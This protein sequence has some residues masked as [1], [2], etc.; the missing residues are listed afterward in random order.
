VASRKPPNTEQVRC[1]MNAQTTAGVVIGAGMFVYAGRARGHHRRLVYLLH[2]RPAYVDQKWTIP[3]RRSPV[4][5]LPKNK[6][7]RTEISPAVSLAAAYPA[8][9]ATSLRL[10][11]ACDRR[12]PRCVEEDVDCRAELAS[13]PRALLPPLSTQANIEVGKLGSV[14]PNRPKAGKPPTS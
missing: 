4:R 6:G 3:I 9:L 10:T 14:Q 8:V 11:R 12:R 13:F 5:V 2:S 7:Y 1:D